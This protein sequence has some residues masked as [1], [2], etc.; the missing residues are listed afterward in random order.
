MPTFSDFAFYH[1]VFGGKLDIGAYEAAAR[2][3]HA[4]MLSRTNGMADKAPAEMHEA[5]M[6]CECELVDVID[7][8]KAPVLPRG[9]GS[10]SNDGYSV[11][12]GAGAPDKE[13]ARERAATCARY[14][15]WPVNLMCGWI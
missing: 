1:D 5:L 7:A 12:M 15:Q 3:A 2:A 13:E 8:W 4:E 9:A 11:S 6:L 10:V 14:L